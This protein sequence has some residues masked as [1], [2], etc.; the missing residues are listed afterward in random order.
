[1]TMWRTVLRL[2]WRI[3]RRDRAALA[4]LALF[5][6]A[7]QR[8]ID[9]AVASRGEWPPEWLGDV[10]AAYAVLLQHPL[11]TDQQVKRYVDFL[12]RLGVGSQATG[13]ESPRRVAFAGFET[14]ELVLEA[15]LDGFF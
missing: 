9:A 6:D 13:A 11:G 10:N 5:A 1:M 14:P 7:R 8:A 3:L 4:V 2:E 12:W 15:H